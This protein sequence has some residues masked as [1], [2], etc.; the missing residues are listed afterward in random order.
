MDGQTS[1]G[2]WELF[3]LILTFSNFNILTLHDET[4]I[5][6][7]HLQRTISKIGLPLNY[8]CL[9]KYIVELLTRNI[10]P[11]NYVHY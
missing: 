8:L 11:P 3:G 4:C 6:I 7:A 1:L 9:L 2:I 10:G 5:A